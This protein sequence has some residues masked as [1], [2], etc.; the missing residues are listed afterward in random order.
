MRKFLFDIFVFF[1]PVLFVV[2][3]YAL[4]VKPNAYGDLGK[5][6]FMPFDRDYAPARIEYTHEGQHEVIHTPQAIM[7][8][9]AVLFVG[10]SFSRFQSY[11]GRANFVNEFARLRPDVLVYNLD[12]DNRE[13]NLSQIVIDIL[14]FHPVLPRRMVLEVTER[15]MMYYYPKVIFDADQ[16]LSPAYFD[17][18]SADNMPVQTG[19]EKSW[20]E[21]CH[22]TILDAQQYF[23][24][25]LGIKN[26]VVK[27]DLSK[28]MF[29]C[30]GDESQLFFYQDDLKCFISPQLVDLT[31][32]NICK[33]HGLA[34]EKGVE[35]VILAPSDKFALYRPWLKR[36]RFDAQSALDF[37]DDFPED[38]FINTR[39]L[40]RPCLERGT[41]DLYLCNDSHWG[42]EAARMVVD[43]LNS[44]LSQ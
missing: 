26:A 44:K 23:K 39:H 11:Y 31:K 3:Y 36:D 2:L 19:K 6:G 28:K 7:D 38:Y 42:P 43:V 8:T 32:Q 37:F 20:Y 16:P 18:P 33:L 40:F 4:A 22:Q 27:A 34:E 14:R 35:L 17:R 9:A 25:R 5:L 12:V 21:T 13:N 30:R 15:S 1:L 29:S 24:K 41:L 10:D